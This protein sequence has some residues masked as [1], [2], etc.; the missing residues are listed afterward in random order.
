MLNPVNA[1]FNFDDLY[2]DE[3]HDVPKQLGLSTM[4]APN[5]T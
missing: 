2:V 4:T 3:T 1:E 5:I